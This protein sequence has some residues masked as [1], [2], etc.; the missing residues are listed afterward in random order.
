MP[1]VLVQALSQRF[2][3]DP[4]PTEEFGAYVGEAVDQATKIEAIGALRIDVRRA[5]MVTA[6]DARRGQQ[7][8]PGES[9]LPEGEPVGYD[10]DLVRAG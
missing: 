2:W 1:A 6:W 3:G 10:P 7:L 8:L 4:I 9:C 5:G